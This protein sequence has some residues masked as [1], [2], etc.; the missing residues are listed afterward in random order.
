M[1]FRQFSP[2]FF[3]SAME[4]SAA[5]TSGATTGAN[6]A[7]AHGT[8]AGQSPEQPRV[9]GGEVLFGRL[10][11]VDD[12]ENNRDMLA[13]RLE[14]SGHS[15]ETVA[16][17]VEAL[18]R[19]QREP[20]DVLLLD[21]TMPEVDGFEVLRRLRQSREATELP[22]IMVTARDHP[23]DVVAALLC[24]ANDYVT[25]PLDYPV[26]LARVQTQL[27]LKRAFDQIRSLERDLQRRNQELESIN[28]RMRRDLLAAARVQQSLLPEAAPKTENVEVAWAYR[29]CNELAGDC[30]NVFALDDE[31][32]GL[33]LLD[34][35]GHGVPAALLSVTLS[36]ILTPVVEHSTLLWGCTFSGQYQPLPPSD[37]VEELNRRFPMNPDVGQ[38]FTLFYAVLNTRTLLLRYTSAGH[39]GPAYVPAAGKPELR[40]HRGFPVGWVPDVQYE[41]HELQLQSGDRV[42][43]YSDGVIEAPNAQREQFGPARLA[44]CLEEVRAEPLRD[45]LDALVGAARSWGGETFVDDVSALAISVQPACANATFQV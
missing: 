45:S 36:R 30:L 22:V 15:V 1:D 37:V 6:L 8:Y 24:G 3:G 42:Y 32:I 13:R 34:V 23:Q 29:P 35:S 20:F 26:V 2:A 11:V 21:V 38:Y 25:K 12:N 4:I 16:S 33:Y 17:G 19:V 27:N 5:S 10:L 43:L 9:L 14:R 39:P 18:E 44:A 31:H 40:K 41:T 7:P 28:A